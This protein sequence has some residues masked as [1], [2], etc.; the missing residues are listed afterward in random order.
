LRK[1]GFEDIPSDISSPTDEDAGPSRP[2]KRRRIGDGSA[3]TSAEASDGDVTLNSTRAR[4]S[5]GTDSA[6]TPDIT[7]G[8]FA[9]D[10]EDD[11]EDDGIVDVDRTKDK[12]AKGRA[13]AKDVVEKVVDDG[14][15]ADYQKRLNSWVDKR[16]RARRMKLGEEDVDDG[17]DEWFKRSP[18]APDHL[19]PNNLKLPGD[20]YPALYDYQKTGV[21]WLGELYASQVGGIV[22]DEMGLGKTYVYLIPS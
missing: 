7:D 17:E 1:P 13:K 18:D 20:I 2:S 12:P 16:G 8:D 15:E 9:V 10:E 5:P 4:K 14:N 21:Q 19:L 11:D 22:G 6:Y 3:I